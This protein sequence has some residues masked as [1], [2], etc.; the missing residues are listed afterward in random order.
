MKFGPSYNSVILHLSL[1]FSPFVIFS[2]TPMP[3]ISITRSL[4]SLP[5]AEWMWTFRS[6]KA[7]SK[8]NVVWIR[9]AKSAPAVFRNGRRTEM[10]RREKRRR[11]STRDTKT[12]NVTRTGVFYTPPVY[13]Y[14]RFNATFSTFTVAECDR[15]LS[16]RE[17][18]PL[19]PS[20]QRHEPHIIVYACNLLVIFIHYLLTSFVFF[21]WV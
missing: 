3:I 8:D 6:Q 13:I 9:A 18:M 14:I 11:L 1:S 20:S 4:F 15:I 21:N 16:R 12:W 7:P 2:R 17:L 19:R 10:G 5:R